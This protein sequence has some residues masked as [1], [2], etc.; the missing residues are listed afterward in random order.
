MNIELA[1]LISELDKSDEKITESCMATKI[2]E[3]TK[4][5]L[6][7][8]SI[9]E[10]MA[11]GFSEDYKHKQSGWGTYFGPMM[12]G[13]GD[14]G[15][16]YESPSISSITEEVVEHWISRSQSTSNPVLKA[17]Y[18]GLIWDLSNAA[19]GKKPDHTV[20]INYVNALL[21]I[22]DKDLCKHPTESIKKITR[23]Y[24]VASG[25][26]NTSLINRCI[27]SAINLE[28]RIAEDSKA[29]LWG[30]CFDL[31]V[32]GKSKYLYEDQREKLI[33]GLEQR[34]MRLSKDSSPWGCES[35]GVRLADY[36][37]VKGNKEE[38][39]RVIKVVGK[40]FEDACDNVAP[41]QASSWLQH[42]HDIYI[43]FNMK[44]D[45]E[46]I[47]KK[48]TEVG[49]DVVDSMQELSHSIEIP[50]EQLDAYFDSMTNG[51]LENTL[52]RIGAQFIPKKDQVEQQVL[53]LAK[54][55][56][57]TNLFTKTLQDHKGRPIATIGSVENDL[58]GSIIHQLSSN[59]N[60]NAFFLRH[61][62]KKALE[63]YD[64]NVQNLT[65]FIF[66][67]PLFE[68]TKQD[69]IHAGLR[70]YLNQD[71]IS[72]IH[73]LVP[74]I[75]A[76]I[77]TLVELTG[78]A[79][80]RSTRQGG[81]QLRTLDNLLRDEKVEECFGIDLSFYFRILLTEQRGWNI[82]NDVCHAISPSGTFNCSVA[83]RI[84]HVIL[85]LAQVRVTNT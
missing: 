12:V 37:R 39:T 16:A 14:D 15:K 5:D 1:Q 74:Q 27:E 64:I 51:G 2:N 8:E 57:L 75:E 65:D 80:L 70:A 55:Y 26:N 35:A 40:S 78:G 38:A 85:C 24:K 58:E 34:L 60:T 29:G 32:L 59:L 33:E 84:M 61:S 47:T 66:K 41:I 31:F 79:T 73:I 13:F 52:I 7:T 4:E 42:V 10:R 21:E 63:V 9:A 6:S 18:C 81:L 71:Y 77:R 69:I 23:A 67:S 53:E 30:F 82:R 49:P 72:A 19:I 11:F 43:S 20:A 76:A 28:D 22:T 17:R 36:Y 83:D 25:L 56:P 46:R 44:S 50:N 45:A 54:N 48:I 62:L 3:V 68:E